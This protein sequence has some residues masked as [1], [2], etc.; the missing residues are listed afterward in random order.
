MEVECVNL[1]QEKT[2]SKMMDLPKL[3]MFSC[4]TKEVVGHA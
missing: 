1:A 4:V 3:S 2:I